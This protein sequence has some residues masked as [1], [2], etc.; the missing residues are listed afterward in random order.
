MNCLSFKEF[1]E[2]YGLKNEATKEIL[3]IL[4]LNSTGIYMRDANFTTVLEL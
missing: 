2:N 4:K 3:D 1:V